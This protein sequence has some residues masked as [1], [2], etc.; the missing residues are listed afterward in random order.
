MNPN[1][2]NEQDIFKTGISI[3]RTAALV[4]LDPRANSASAGRI[5]TRR[6]LQITAA[7]DPS[8]LDKFVEPTSLLAFD[9]WRP[10]KACS[11]IAAERLR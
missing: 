5:A 9:H 1:D 6:M 4:Q 11:R 10:R 2:S 7:P 8:V 3:S